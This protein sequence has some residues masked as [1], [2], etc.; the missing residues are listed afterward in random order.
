MITF[1][2]LGSKG[3]LG[4]QLWQ[5]AS[6]I[7]IAAKNGTYVDFPTWE[8]DKYFKCQIGDSEFK[9]ANT[10]VKEKDFMFNHIPLPD[11]GNYDL[12]G[13]FQSAKYWQ[14]YEK[15][16]ETLFEFTDN[17]TNHC[18]SLLPNNGRKN[19][20]IHVRRGD[21]VGNPSH[22]NLSI[23]YYLNALNKLN[24][25][26]FNLVFFS[27]DIDYAKFHFGCLPNSYFP[28]G[29]EIE[30][31]CT[32]SLCDHFIIA[33]SSFSWWAAWLCKNPDK[34]IYRPEEH[35]A[36]NQLKHDIKDL[37][38]SEWRVI[39]DNDKPNL[40]D[41]TFIIPVKYDHADRKANLT[42]SLKH[43]TDNFAT[44]I[45]IIEQGG[46]KFAYL[47]PAYDYAQF[48]G[49]RFHR[50]RM[51]NTIAKFVRTPLIVNWDADMLLSPVQIWYSVYMLRAGI[52]IVYPY[53][54]NW[55]NIPRQ[56]HQLLANNID[57]VIGKAFNGP[58]ES[59]GGAIF[60]NRAKFISVGG[61][62]EKFI[63]WGPEDAERY[64]RFLKMGLS[65]ERIKG[66]IYHLE[67]YRGQDSGRHNPHL[68][69]NRKEWHMIRLMEPEALKEYVKTWEWTSF[70]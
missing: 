5:I 25:E 11:L 30:D 51:I 50:T 52:D 12:N 24:W 3:R 61:E 55:R 8:Y 26:D 64:V 28:H 27:D 49:D 15:Q 6:C 16:I 70:T 66:S 33:N 46:N 35:F 58:T 23:R 18:L 10:E 48:G 14:G 56:T 31:L 57:W 2:Q 20:A 37:Y 7:G 68:E 17:L 45:S 44:E 9:K 47:E 1:S 29:S 13:Y 19:I 59:W 36:G 34:I 53:D 69:A 40:L 39:S 60:M 21:Y 54:G 4:N 63:S 67:H 22:Y 42:L 32:M 62:N 65:V 43:I 41:T 38:P